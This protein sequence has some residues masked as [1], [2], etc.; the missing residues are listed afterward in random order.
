MAKEWS[1][2]TISGVK[3]SSLIIAQF[4]HFSLHRLKS[5]HQAEDL[6]SC[7]IY[8]KQCWTPRM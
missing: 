6:W 5:N 1:N 3:A 7:R 8:L 4:Q 2:L